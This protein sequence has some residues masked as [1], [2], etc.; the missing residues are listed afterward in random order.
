MRFQGSVYQAGAQ[1]ALADNTSNL[2]NWPDPKNKFAK[3]GKFFDPENDHKN[4]HV[5]PATHHTF[6]I[7]KP[8]S[9]PGF[10]QNPQQKR[11]SSRN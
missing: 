7:K 4:H 1:S 9:A 3:S 2:H 5:L 6:T 8:R 10:S 11:T